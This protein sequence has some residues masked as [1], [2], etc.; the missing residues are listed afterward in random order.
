MNVPL[1]I[2]ASIFALV[3]FWGIFI[4]FI[5][6]LPLIWFGI[7][8]YGLGTRFT[9]IAL[10]T[11][12]LLGI[13]SATTYLV[14]YA[15][16]TFGAKRFGASRQGMLGAIIGSLVGFPFVPPF[17]FMIGAATG[18]LLA[19]IYLSGRTGAAAWRASKGAL[20]GLLI[21]LLAKIIIAGI[22]IGVFLRAIL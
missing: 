17:G 22:I 2:I 15:A 1:L 8:I 20:L 12:L 3:G 18:T 5:P 7:L 21:S 11:V 19:E 4:P 14:D 16:I 6:D 9:E 13:F 10:P